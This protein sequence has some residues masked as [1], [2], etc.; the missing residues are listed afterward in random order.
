[1][2]DGEWR[3]LIGDF[4]ARRIDGPDFQQR[5]LEARRAEVNVG[6]SQ[7][8]AVDLLF[9][10]VDA[11]CADPR[12]WGPHDID[13]EQLRVEARRCLARWDEPWPPLRK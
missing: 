2:T 10:E 3:G 1:M 8:Y 7:R 4:I 13:E 12:L 6:I 11:Y 9:Y 5:F